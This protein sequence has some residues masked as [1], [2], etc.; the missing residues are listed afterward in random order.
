MV[1]LQP[2]GT[3]SPL[4]GDHVSEADGGHGDEAEV[5]GV[6]EAPVLVDGEEV[7]AHLRMV[8]KGKFYYG[9]C[10]TADSQTVI[11]INQLFLG[12]VKKDVLCLLYS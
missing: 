1:S 12:I 4:T 11:S 8:R 9:Y 7:S 5:D 10:T 2:I 3:V 6:E